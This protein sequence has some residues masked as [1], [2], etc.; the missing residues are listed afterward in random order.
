M[1]CIQSRA[2]GNPLPTKSEKTFPEPLYERLK[3]VFFPRLF[4]A[5]VCLICQSSAYNRE[6]N[7]AE[8]RSDLNRI[9]SPSA[10]HPSSLLPYDGL[11]RSFAFYRDLRVA[12]RHGLVFGTQ[13]RVPQPRLLARHGA[14]D[15]MLALA[16]TGLPARER[17]ALVLQPMT[18]L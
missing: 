17:R 3:L 5:L 13:P 11:C 8:L 4:F 16:V 10:R 14:P 18:V 15:V 9:R 1:C 2:L 7:G 12:R 6:L